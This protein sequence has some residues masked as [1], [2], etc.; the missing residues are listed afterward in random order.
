M[1][2]VSLALALTLG[3]L[4]TQAQSG[5]FWG[6]LYEDG[7]P[8][9]L[10]VLL[11][12]PDTYLGRSVPVVVQVKRVGDLDHPL[13][14][15]FDRDRFLCFSAWGDEA[16]LWDRDAYAADHPFFFA[17]RAGT[18]SAALTGAPLY[19][20]WALTLVVAEI[21]E[22]RPWFLV[23]SARRQDEAWTEAAL[24]RTVKGNTLAGLDRPDAAAREFRG[25][26]VDGL[27]KAARLYLL[28]REA[29]AWGAAGKN[30]LALAAARKGLALAGDDLAWSALVTKFAGLAARRPGPTEAERAPVPAAVTGPS[31]S[32]DGER[33]PRDPRQQ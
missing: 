6:D 30:A 25:A 14:A 13:A 26:E 9:P 21:F 16:P 7:R 23:E 18:A 12:A 27:P 3:S 19:S 29:Q 5:G 11:A 33:L 22:G 2:R 15:R 31:G 20:R 4:P 17:P 24:I 10:S 32:P 1:L 28:E 8:V